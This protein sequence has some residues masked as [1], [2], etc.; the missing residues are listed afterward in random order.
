MGKNLT[1]QQFSTEIHKRKAFVKRDIFVYIFLV[2]LIA[3]LFL[4][5]IVFNKDSSLGFKVSIDNKTILTHV[6][7]EDFNI[8]ENYLDDIKI[9]RTDDGYLIKISSKDGYN[10]L[11]VNEQNKSVKMQ[12]SDCPSKNC[13]YMNAITN[14]G[15]IYCAPRAIK[16]SPLADTEFIP[17]ITGGI[18]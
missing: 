3:S 17:P 6:Y 4:F 13:V 18:N 10:I 7:G 12:D 5:L 14:A 1:K 2:V 8:D 11:L 16:I 9:E 15:A